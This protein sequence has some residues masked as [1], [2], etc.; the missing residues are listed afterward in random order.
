[1][2]YF[3]EKNQA[4]NAV[5]KNITDL[6]TF[7]TTEYLYLKKVEEKAPILKKNDYI[8]FLKDAQAEAKKRATSKTLVLEYSQCYV[9]TIVFNVIAVASTMRA[10]MTMINKILKGIRK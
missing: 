9:I 7:Y 5:V 1:L 2:S 4:E 10:I 6:K 3:A 8:N